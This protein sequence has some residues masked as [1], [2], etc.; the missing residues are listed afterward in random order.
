MI[1]RD[2]AERRLEALS[3]R[4]GRPVRLDQNGVAVLAPREG[5]AVR[6][7]LGDADYPLVMW[8]ALFNLQALPPETTGDLMRQTMA[9]NAPGQG[10]NGAAFS[11]DASGTN[12]GLGMR[13]PAH[14]DDQEFVAMVGRLMATT[15]T[16]LHATG[17][18]PDP[19]VLAV[20]SVSA[21]LRV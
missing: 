15:A 1:E 2:I 10:L 12:L 8:S 17:E 21:G 19:S 11:L 16:L 4:I 20:G 3:H 6:L 9:L 14:C 18:K 13:V 5:A 7:C